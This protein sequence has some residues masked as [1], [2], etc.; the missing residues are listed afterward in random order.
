[1]TWEPAA[2]IVAVAAV[3]GVAFPAVA[4]AT[5]DQAP[6]TQPVPAALQSA[7]QLV[8]PVNSI[9][10]LLPPDMRQQA[11]SDLVRAIPALEAPKPAVPEASP[12]EA[13]PR[14]PLRPSRPAGGGCARSRS[15]R[16]R[17]GRGCGHGS[18]DHSARRR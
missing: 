15:R 2:A 16:V 3:T 11:A 8:E 12:T 9:V 7:P 13:P 18:R 6:E 17:S 5:P 1:M 4:N 10:A 14:K